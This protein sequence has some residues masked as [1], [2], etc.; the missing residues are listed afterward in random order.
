MPFLKIYI[1]MYA[2]EPNGCWHWLGTTY[3]HHQ[4]FI[5][6]Y[7][8]QSE[9]SLSSWFKIVTGM[10]QGDI[11]SPLLFG[12][13]IDFAMRT[14]VDRDRRGLAL[15]PRS[16]WYP[17][18]K[19]ADLDYAEDIALFEES[20]AETADTTKAIRVTAGNFGLQMSFKKTEI[21]SVSQARVPNHI[22]LL[23]NEGHIKVVQH[24]KYLGAYCNWNGANTKKLNNRIGR[25][26]AAFRELDKVWRNRNINV[27]TKI[28]F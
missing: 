26:S 25:V 11:W 8:M 2:W 24:F 1:D 27:D 4:K 20:E 5:L 21:M 6:Q 28:K 10:R 15:I 12:L 13:T 19:L 9:G 14:A 3:Q 23:G 7:Y 22:V 16:F 17:A 18:V